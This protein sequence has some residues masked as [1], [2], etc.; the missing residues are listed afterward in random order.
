MSEKITIKNVSFDK[1]SYIYWD[2]KDINLKFKVYFP[3]EKTIKNIRIEYWY[4]FNSKVSSYSWV[5]TLEEKSITLKENFTSYIW[6]EESFSL[7][8]PILFPYFDLKKVSSKSFIRIIVDVDWSLFDIKKD[9][10]PDIKYSFDDVENISFIESPIKEYKSNFDNYEN[11]HFCLNKLSFISIVNFLK[12][13]KYIGCSDYISKDVLNS[14]LSKN[15]YLNFVFNLLNLFIYSLLAKASVIVTIILFLPTI[16]WIYNNISLY[17]FIWSTL[18]ILLTLFLTWSFRYFIWKSIFKIKYNPDLS[19]SEKIANNLKNNNFSLDDIF[20]EFF[21]KI[22]WMH[23]W[24]FSWYIEWYL[25]TYHK[26]TRSSW[27][28]RS[29]VTVYDISMFSRLKIFDIDWKWEVIKSSI[30]TIENNYR[31]YC[32]KKISSRDIK[33]NKVFYKLVI[34]FDSDYLPDFSNKIEIKL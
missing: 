11:N 2:D 18:F 20:Y 32:D 34:K 31:E 22:P 9:Y 16:T 12:L 14:I 26:E 5:H 19:I 4:K 1:T 24:N 10:Y 3:L 25:Q 23:K 27:K 7:K 21:I 30:R 15:I 6:Q 17:V 33:W 28:S 8:I 29:T 13:K